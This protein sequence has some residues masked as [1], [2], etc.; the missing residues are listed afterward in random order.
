MR[1]A[2]LEA[3]CDGEAAD[4]VR[5]ERAEEPADVVGQP[6]GRRA[7]RGREQLRGHRAE[8][9]EVAR[10]E[11]R[12]ARTERRAAADS[13]ALRVQQARARRR[14]AVDHVGAASARCGRRRSR[15]TRSRATSPPASATIQID[16]R[17]SESPAPP[18]RNRPRQVRR[19][20]RKQPHHANIVAGV[21][22]R[23][24]PRHAGAGAEE[25]V[26]KIRGRR[27]ARAGSRSQSG[28]SST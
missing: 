7:D 28:D 19:D 2:A 25:D 23:D 14:R 9:A 21:H 27:S 5:R 20:P 18:S 4:D 8:S 3:V 10:A 1:N 24:R 6:L 12:Q 11:E 17:T 15:T 22:R 13:P 16:D 26:A